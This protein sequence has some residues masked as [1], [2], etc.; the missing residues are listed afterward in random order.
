MIQDRRP[1]ALACV[2]HAD[3]FREQAGHVLVRLGGERPALV[4]GCRIDLRADL[5]AVPGWSRVDEARIVK[6]LLLQG[7]TFGNPEEIAAGSFLGP[8][9]ARLGTVLQSRR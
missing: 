3:R 6:T 7:V 8:G 1:H 5:D 2:K 4:P 9:P